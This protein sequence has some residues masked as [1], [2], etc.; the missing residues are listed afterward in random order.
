MIVIPVTVGPLN[1]NCY[2]LC[3]EQT[4]DCAIIDP[5]DDADKI[6][7]KI[8]TSNCTPTAVLLTHGH[9]DHVKGVLPL[10]RQY[11]GIAVYI[12]ANE[13]QGY[14]KIFPALQNTLHYGEGDTVKIGSLEV[15][16]L[17]TPGHSSGSVTLQVESVLFCGDTLFMGACGRSDYYSGN[18][19]QLIASLRRIGELPGDFLVYPG[20]MEVTTLEDERIQN[21]AL[22]YA[23]WHHC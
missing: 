22:R 5:G 9:V 19:T 13:P 8:Q 12:S 16:I 18:Q 2:I 20:H 10:Q 1:T 6:M 21:P 7:E 3:D 4:G 14:G 17:E 11:P 23:L 15:H